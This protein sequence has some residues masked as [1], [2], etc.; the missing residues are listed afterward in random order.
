MKEYQGEYVEGDCTWRGSR[1][2]GQQALLV[3][4]PGGV[5]GEECR[6]DRGSQSVKQVQ[7]TG[8]PGAGS[9]EGRGSGWRERSRRSQGTRLCRALWGVLLE[10]RKGGEERGIGDREV[11][12][13][14]CQGEQRNGEVAKGGVWTKRT[15]FQDRQE[16]QCLGDGDGVGGDMGERGCGLIL[17][18][19]CDGAPRG[20]WASVC[21]W[22]PYPA[23]QGSAECEDGWPGELL[24]RSAAPASPGELEAGRQGG[25]KTGGG[26]GMG[27]TP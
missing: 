12:T 10:V 16:T 4:R 3:R 20:C 27:G 13:F 23:S 6:R 14:C 25:L 7:E 8:R 19:G 2:E 15:P 5:R 21:T 9:G 11:S 24:R 17:V 22:A 1:G 26:D 18:R